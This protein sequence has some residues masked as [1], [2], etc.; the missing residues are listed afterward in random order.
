MVKVSTCVATIMGT[1][2]LLLLVPTL[3]PGE[4]HDFWNKTMAPIFAHRV[5]HFGLA[6]LPVGYASDAMKRDYYL[7]QKLLT[8]YCPEAVDKAPGI[9]HSVSRTGCAHWTVL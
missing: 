1:I 7:P 5:A 2:D 6:G 3:A 9:R 8:A 4:S